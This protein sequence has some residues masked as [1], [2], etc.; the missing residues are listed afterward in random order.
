MDIHTGA[1][2]AAFLQILGEIHYKPLWY[3]HNA[4]IRKESGIHCLL[5]WSVETRD[6]NLFQLD[7]EKMTS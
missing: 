7:N 3:G 5:S 2:L 4:N 6:R 1:P